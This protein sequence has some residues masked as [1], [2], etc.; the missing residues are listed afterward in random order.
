METVITYQG[1]YDTSDGRK[2]WFDITRKMYTD[3][4]TGRFTGL[5]QD[6]RTKTEIL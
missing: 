2:G 5:L 1:L 4:L 3:Y 6:V